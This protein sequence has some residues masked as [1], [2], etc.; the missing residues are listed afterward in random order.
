MSA[1]NK[2]IE[3]WATNAVKDCLSMTDTLSPYI[4]ENDKTPIWDGDVLIYKNN[5]RNNEGVVGKITVQVK[6]ELDDKIK[7]KQCSFSVEMSS[8]VSYKNDGGTIFFLVLISNKNPRL[9]KVFY[10]TLTPLKINNYIKGHEEQNARTIKLMELPKDKYKVQTIFLNF[11]NDCN[12]QHSF[13]DIPP[14]CLDD[15]CKRQDIVKVSSSIAFFSPKNKNL[16]PIDAFL[17]SETYWYV[18]I[19]GSPIPHPME[20]CTNIAISFNEC[21]PIFINGEQHANYVSIVKSKCDTVI[22]FGDSTTITISK[23]KKN[24]EMKYTPSS[25][26]KNRIIDQAFIIQT[27]KS[28]EIA[29]G[30]GKCI[31]LGDIKANCDFDIT[32]AENELES[33]KRI[34]DFLRSLSIT[35]DLILDKIGTN[36]SLEELS[37]IMSSINGRKPVKFTTDKYQGCYLYRKSISNLKVLF[38]LKEVDKKKSLYNIYNFFDH[39]GIV[40]VVRGKEEHITSIYSVLT[41]D[42]YIELSNIDFAKILQSFKDAVALNKNIYSQVN[43]DLLNLL[44]AYDKGKN[45]SAKILNAAKDIALWLL[46]ES[47]SVLPSEIKTINYLQTIKRER[48]LN[49][50]ENRKLLDIAENSNNDKMLKIGANLLL[51]NYKSAQMQYEQMSSQDQEI[52]KSFP[53]YKFWK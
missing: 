13:K 4:K 23:D 31:K 45:R 9:R 24:F 6:G 35:D 40:K 8:L 16:S 33:Y 26:L 28:G 2:Q 48:E 3:E 17:N 49:N 19:K 1:N 51:E 21:I 22:K 11:Y 18:N 20:L 34:D 30:E 7:K 38:L 27:I 32:Y 41:P 50:E 47:G 37:L 15:L 42:D 14:I 10:E 52:F 44:L 36:S 25:S 29:L 43:Y 12:K 39:K 46:D 53:I 5:S